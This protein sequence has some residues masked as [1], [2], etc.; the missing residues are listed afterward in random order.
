MTQK[1]VFPIDGSTISHHA[2]ITLAIR[3][4]APPSPHAPVAKAL[5]VATASSGAR[6]WA[7]FCRAPRRNI[8]FL[9][10]YVAFN[11][12]Y[13]RYR[14]MPVSMQF[15]AFLDP[16]D[17]WVVWD[18]KEQY[19]AEVGTRYLQSLPEGQKG[20]LHNAKYLAVEKWRRRTSS[21]QRTH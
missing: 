16:M 5:Q 17:N 4:S 6:H 2:I 13:E 15:E 11:V 1:R 12:S 21:V 18:C 19:F 7:G 8:G 20:V 14:Q 9:E 10:R 3:L